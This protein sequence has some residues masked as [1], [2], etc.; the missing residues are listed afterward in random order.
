MTTRTNKLHANQKK[1]WKKYQV[2]I[3][4]AQSVINHSIDPV[5]NLNN[6]N[7][8]NHNTNDVKSL[9]NN[10]L[11]QN[12]HHHHQQP[13]QANRIQQIEV[14]ETKLL[15]NATVD[16]TLTKNT[17]TSTLK[18]HY[19]SLIAHH[20][21]YILRL[22]KG[23]WC[24]VINGIC[25]LEIDGIETIYRYISTYDK[26]TQDLIIAIVDFDMSVPIVQGHIKINLILSPFAATLGNT[27]NN[28]NQ[29][30]DFPQDPN[31]NRT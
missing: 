21:Y 6:T 16:N 30:F 22:I 29:G 2:H 11:P 5:V 12:H 26:D 15:V 7:S 1:V 8:N 23:A 24:E 28:N 4:N 25:T 3:Q 17:F 13:L 27:S 9:D 14:I 31:A 18:W 19:N 20:A 10:L